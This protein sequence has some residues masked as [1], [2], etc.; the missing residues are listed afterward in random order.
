MFEAEYTHE[1]DRCSFEVLTRRFGIEDASVRAVGEVVHDIDVRDGK[2]ARPETS[3]VERL[4]NGIALTHPEDEG[5]IGLGSQL[6]DALYEAW[7]RKKS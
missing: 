3:G 4:V 7:R 2:F 6:F 5:R 1:G